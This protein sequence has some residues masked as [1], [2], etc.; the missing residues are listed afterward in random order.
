VPLSR[1]AAAV[2]EEQ[3]AVTSR[4]EWVFAS[5]S[6]RGG[7]RHLQ[8]LSHAVARIRL[9]AGLAD[10]T[11]HDLRRTAATIMG[12]AGVRPDVIERVLNHSPS[13][14]ERTYNRATYEAEKRAAVETVAIS[15]DVSRECSV[16][17]IESGRGRRS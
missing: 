3:R 14:I 4:S 2:I 7:G 12:N 16:V 6:S 1:A 11:P 17:N 9:A 8:W 15:F 13:R 10:F 5:P